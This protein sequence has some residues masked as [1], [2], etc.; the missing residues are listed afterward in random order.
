MVAQLTR[1]N[2][3]S[4]NERRSLMGIPAQIRINMQKAS[5]IYQ[6]KLWLLKKTSH[7]SDPVGH[8]N[9]E[10]LFLDTANIFSK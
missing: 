2:S 5:M 3:W 4:R 6:V 1:N 9:V 10:V 8:E 7:T